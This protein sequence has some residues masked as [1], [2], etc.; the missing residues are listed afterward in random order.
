VVPVVARSFNLMATLQFSLQ[1]DPAVLSFKAVEQLGLDGLSLSSFATDRAALGSIVLSWDDLSGLGRSISDGSVLFAI[2]FTVA[3]PAGASS[4]VRIVSTPVAIE[5]AAVIGGQPTAI[6][7]SLTDGQIQ[8]LSTVRIAGA[9]R[10][11]SLDRGV[12][13]AVV[14]VYSDTGVRLDGTSTSDDGTFSF[15]SSLGGP[16]SVRVSPPTG[17]PASQGIS[18]LDITLVRR[19]ILGISALDS[20][21]KLLAADVNGSGG[22]STL[23]ITL[24]RRV[25]LG[26]TDAFPIGPWRFVPASYSFPNPSSPWAPDSDRLIPLLDSDRLGTDFIGIRT[27]DVNGSWTSPPVP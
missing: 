12:P 4:L 26:I 11:Y 2:R 27:G 1:W 3:G 10:Y 22:V 17:G 8:V 7:T 21:Y 18:T 5:A 19:H 9:V 23:D 20:P 6:Q 14:G 25:I 16:R 24:M 13:G 15:L